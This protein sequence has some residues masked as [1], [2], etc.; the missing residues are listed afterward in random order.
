[1]EAVQKWRSEK[2]SRLSG[3]KQQEEDEEEE[4]IYTIHNQEVSSPLPSRISRTSFEKSGWCWCGGRGFMCNFLSVR[5]VGFLCICRPMM[6]RARRSRME[7]K[8]E[9][10]SSHMYLFPH[11]ER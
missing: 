3:E 11:R 6:M 8:A 9:S 5:C 4:S 1:M 10:P 7:R 2:E